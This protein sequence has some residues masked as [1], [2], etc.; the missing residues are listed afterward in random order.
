MNLKTNLGRLRLLG[1]I[2]GIS[3][4][5]L[6]GICMPLKYVWDMP[7]FTYPVGLAHGVLFVA[8]C[9]WVLIVGMEKKWS[10]TVIFLALAASLLPFATFVADA[11][12]FRKS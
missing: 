10:F 12:L 3:Y 4:L 7:Q 5:L 9:F 6:L 11:K 8:Y 1:L 2:E